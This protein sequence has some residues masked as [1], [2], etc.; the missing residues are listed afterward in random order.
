MRALI[1]RILAYIR[2]AEKE[3]REFDAHIEKYKKLGVIK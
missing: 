1:K 2:K 3:A